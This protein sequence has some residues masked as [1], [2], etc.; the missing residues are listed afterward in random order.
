VAVT[1]TAAVMTAT[2]TAMAMETKTVKVTVGG[3][4][5]GSDIGPLINLGMQ[6]DRRSARTWM[7]RV[8]TTFVVV[9][10]GRK[11]FAREHQNGF[12]ET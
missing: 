7:K 9:V 2:A 5:N 6:H 12:Y 1:A 4:G 11:G 8:L 10:G 3:V